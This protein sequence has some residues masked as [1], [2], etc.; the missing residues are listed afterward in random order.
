MHWYKKKVEVEALE[1]GLW[2]LLQTWRVITKPEDATSSFAVDMWL[3][4]ESKFAFEAKLG[5]FPY[6]QNTK[7]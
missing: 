5:I 1:E 6:L 4:W 7:I 2:E 3:Y